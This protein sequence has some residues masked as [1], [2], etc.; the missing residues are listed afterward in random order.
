[1]LP[2]VRMPDVWEPLVQ[3]D[4]ARWVA[5]R[6]QLH[7]AAQAA[8]GPGKQLLPHQP[9]FSEQS[10]RWDG[11]ARALAQGAIDAARPVR[12]ALRPDPPALLLLD[13]DGAAALRELLLD[14]SSL[15]DA[16]GWLETE[17]G[18][19]LGR[20]VALDRPAEPPAL[21]A[22]TDGRFAT[23][24]AEAFRLA[25]AWFANGHRLLAAVAARHPR[26]APVRCWP[27][28]FDIAT[29]LPLDEGGDPETARSIGVGLQP[30]DGA[31]PEPYLYVTPWPYPDAARLPPLAVGGW[32]TEGWTGAVLE[33]E[34][35]FAAGAAPEQARLAER[36][37]DAAIAACRELLERD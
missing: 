7:A 10:F 5:A 26:A 15:E 28:H 21:P 12:S 33:A 17:L 29:L 14:G 34:A 11:A 18:A 30:G 25:A 1:M 19:L 32:H 6:Q 4:T 27:H 36:F 37:L 13:G 2:E 20:P 23:A 9:D 22:G 24:D 31:R 16:F 3:I 8:A 35:L